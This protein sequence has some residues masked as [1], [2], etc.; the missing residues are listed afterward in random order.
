MNMVTHGISRR[1]LTGAVAMAVFLCVGWLLADAAAGQGADVGHAKADP[2]LP[3]PVAQPEGAG[4]RFQPWRDVA[5]DD[6]A[7]PPKRSPQPRRERKGDVAKAE[8]AAPGKPPRPAAREMTVFRL[9][10]A[11]AASVAS[12]LSGLLDSKEAKVVPDHETN[13]LFVMTSP[14]TTARVKELV[15]L[16][17]APRQSSRD[18]ETRVFPLKY[19]DLEEAQAVLAEILADKDARVAVEEGTRSMVVAA[20]PEVLEKVAGLLKDLDVPPPSEP[21]Q[22]IKVFTLVNVD[23]DSAAKVLSELLQP[24]GVR[25]AV[26]RRTKSLIAMGSHET[27]SVMDA[28]LTRLDQTAGEEPKKPAPLA[29][30]RV[31]VVW[32]ASGLSRDD[33]PKPA[34]DLKEVVTELGKLGVGE[35]REVGQAI[36][37]TMPDG[38][39]FEIS[40]SP[41]FDDSSA[42][43]RIAGELEEEDG[44]PK[45]QIQI[46][47]SERAERSSS[48]RSPAR[49]LVDLETT[50]TAPCGHYVVLGVT[51]VGKATSVFVVQVAPTK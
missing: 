15:E 23:P 43:L 3:D 46:S 4:P 47:A 12:V 45:L 25:F 41:T 2:S 34:D 36:V 40:S 32:L 37:N 6:A 5:D 33:A 30:F 8:P 48:A 16:L 42:E 9:R 19:A 26:D 17:D 50:I 20:S 35:L 18:R 39:G 51:P 11:E 38:S 21:F 7:K 22:Q 1:L 29:T 13:C 27:L 44:T 49:R 10:H 14:E 24:R 31:R 28:L